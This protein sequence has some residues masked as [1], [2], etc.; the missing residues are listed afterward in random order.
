MTTPIPGDIDSIR[1]WVLERIE[2]TDELDLSE[3]IDEGRAL[4][5]PGRVTVIAFRRHEQTG[6]ASCKRVARRGR[7]TLIARKGP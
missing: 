5:I 2:S 4:G 1:A 3:L 7:I 6:A